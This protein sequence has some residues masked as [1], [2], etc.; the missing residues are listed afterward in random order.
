MGLLL[1]A[2]AF[3]QFTH[4]VDFMVLMPLGPNL[5]RTLEIGPSEF[6]I[7]VSCYT[8]AA[9][10]SG[11]LGSF[12]ID[13][14]DRKKALVF[15]YIGFSAGTI[16]C[17]L[18]NSFFALLVARTVTG[19][20]G[21]ILGS[22]VLAIVGDSFS[23]EKRGRAF[24]LVMMSFSAASIFGVPFSLYLAT[25]WDWHAPFLFVG[26][27]GTLALMVAWRVIPPLRG[28]LTNAAGA[29]KLSLSEVAF[30][31]R[32]LRGLTLMF[33]LVIGQFAVIPFLSPSLVLNAG[34]SEAQLPLIY[35]TG[36]IISMLTSPFWG[37]MTD[38]FGAPRVLMVG[39][40]SSMV[41]FVWITHLGPTPLP[42]VL[43]ISCILFICM[44]GRMVPA[45]TLLQNQ[46]EPANRGAYMGIMSSVQQFSSALAAFLAGH[47]V[48]QSPEGHIENYGLIGW[49][50]CGLGLLAIIVAWTFLKRGG[51]AQTLHATELPEE[52]RSV[53][54]K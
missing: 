25:I 34:L 9:G 27:V 23:P 13:R 2:L 36:G 11:L 33:C 48:Y 22:I 29:P 39:V 3:I 24:G 17:G 38:R 47:I 4:I 15:L 44:G 6:S 5:M 20:F 37:R 43:A 7:L 42:T 31:S 30:E 10:A 8:F 1:F 32:R 26:A 19:L 41:P 18:V 46:V 51:P 21:G 16:A 12:F 14:F 49:G 35:L 40:V 52:F 53:S 28:H 54:A 50:A 45:M